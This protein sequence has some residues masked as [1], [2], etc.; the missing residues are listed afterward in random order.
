MA[1][2]KKTWQEKL[3]TGAT[4][5]VERCLKRFADIPE[6]A[7]MVVPTPET[8]DAYIRTIPPGTYVPLAQMRADMAAVHHAEYCC[9]ITAGIFLRICS[10]A[11][12]EA[13]QNGTPIESVTPFWRMVDPASPMAKKL[14]FGTDF[15]AEMQT[16]E[17]MNLPA[18]RSR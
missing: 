9:P 18:R 11:A 16:H 4:V 10:E 2:K 6:G 12:W 15:V 14:T 7:T 1:Y 3:H 8:V 5:K 13:Y 17:G